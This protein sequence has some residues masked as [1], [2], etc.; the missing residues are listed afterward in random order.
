MNISSCSTRLFFFKLIEL[1]MFSKELVV[2]S[3]PTVHSLYC[4]GVLIDEFL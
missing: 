3:C 4:V 1:R 2:N